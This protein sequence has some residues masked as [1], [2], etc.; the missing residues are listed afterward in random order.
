LEVI[1][2]Y[3]F[4]PESIN[5][6]SFN[7]VYGAEA[8]IPV[9]IREP[10]LRRLNFNKKLNEESLHIRLDLVVEL[11]E[12]AQIRNIAAK[13]RAARKHNSKLQPHAFI[14]GELVSCHDNIYLTCGMYPTSNFVL[15]KMDDTS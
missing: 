9:E 5:E 7:L 15:V 3:R 1:C 11:R 2:A 4:T 6:S 8:M 12:K 14:K 13:Q 10:S